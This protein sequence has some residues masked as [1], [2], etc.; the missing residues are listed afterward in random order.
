MIHELA[1]L[2]VC[3][4]VIVIANQSAA[5]QP[6]NQSAIKQT[7]WLASQLGTKP[8]SLISKQ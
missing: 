2:S 1:S 5:S 6:L 4:L 8:V 3:P 7:I